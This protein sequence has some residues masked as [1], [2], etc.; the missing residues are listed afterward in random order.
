MNRT[1]EQLVTIISRED[2]IANFTCF[3]TQIQVT[4]CV[5]IE[6]LSQSYSGTR[7]ALKKLILSHS[8]QRILPHQ[9]RYY[10]SFISSLFSHKAQIQSHPF[11]VLQLISKDIPA[12]CYPSSVDRTY[13]TTLAR[14]TCLRR[15]APWQI[16]RPEAYPTLG[17][18]VVAALLGRQTTQSCGEQVYGGDRH[19][20]RLRGPDPCPD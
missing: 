9:I 16:V 13:T 14:P 12:S 4:A 3:F 20:H 7:F 10:L 17:H 2:A 8:R 19:S 5:D 18:V 11:R 6:L 1:D 15:L